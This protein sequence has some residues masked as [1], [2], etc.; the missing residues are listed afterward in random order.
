MCVA[1]SACRAH[2]RGAGNASVVSKHMRRDK[3]DYNQG[4]STAALSNQRAT[5]RGIVLAFA[6]REALP[7][8]YTRIH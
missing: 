3:G 4:E 5:P 2:V 1:Q 7:A 8:C 6:F